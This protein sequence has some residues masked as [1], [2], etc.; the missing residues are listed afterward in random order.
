[1]PT[2]DDVRDIGFAPADLTDSREQW[3]WETRYPPPARRAIL[4]EAAYLL[5]L[6][7]IVVAGMFLLWRGYAGEWFSLSD[8]QDKTLRQ[9]CYAWLGGLLGG[10][11]FAMKWLYHSVAKGQWHQ[12]RRLW[13]VF[14]PLISGALALTLLSLLFGRV[15][16]AVD[17]SI[18]RSSPAIVGLGFFIGY[19]S[20]GAIAAL[21]EAADRLFGS[22]SRARRRRSGDGASGKSDGSTHA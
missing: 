2:E 5:L 6:F 7:A 1:M 17:Q 22:S 19:F 20:D 4:L 14:A 16:I 8:P 13:R 18:I 3:D 21:A 10:V 12:D 11:L 15:V 9:Y